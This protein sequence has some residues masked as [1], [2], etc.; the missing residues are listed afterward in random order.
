MNN[1]TMYLHRTPEGVL[2]LLDDIKDVFILY[3][4]KYIGRKAKIEAVKRLSKG[5]VR[6]NPNMTTEEVNHYIDQN[7]FGT[8]KWAKYHRIFSSVAAESEEIKEEVSYMA[9]VE[10]TMSE[11]YSKKKI[12][13]YTL[14]YI[15]KNE[16]FNTTLIQVNL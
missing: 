13:D 3:K 4:R 8:E 16:L 14:D 11:R 9:T 15:K 5:L 12:I 7:I 2:L 10:I 6:L 1:I